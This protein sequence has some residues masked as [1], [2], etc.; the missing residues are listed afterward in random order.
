MDGSIPENWPE[1][2]FCLVFF[3]MQGFRLPILPSLFIYIYVWLDRDNPEGRVWGLVE[4]LRFLGYFSHFF[5]DIGDLCT[6]IYMYLELFLLVLLPA[7][8]KQSC[9][10]SHL[11]SG[12]LANLYKKLC[13]TQQK[14]SAV[15]PENKSVYSEIANSIKQTCTEYVNQANA[16]KIHL[17]K[18]PSKKRKPKKQGTAKSE[19]SEWEVSR[20][21]D[22]LNLYTFEIPSK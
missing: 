21:Y 11:V 9:F 18:A 14:Q 12:N 16:V 3:F 19:E 6:C 15:N 22:I 17:P 1:T 5:G 13:E 2:C 8:L 10:R 20:I 4:N 7:R